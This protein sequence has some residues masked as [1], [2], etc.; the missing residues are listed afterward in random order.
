MTKL[1]SSSTGDSVI[2]HSH[3]T[4]ANT[5]VKRRDAAK[6]R[7]KALIQKMRLMKAPKRHPDP[8]TRSLGRGG[9]L[10]LMSRAC[11]AVKGSGGTRA[12]FHKN[13]GLVAEV[14][15]DRPPVRL[16]AA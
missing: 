11:Q 9:V 3:P 14:W 8:A 10:P 7:P 16:F 12:I 2:P 1:S 4:L 5:V 13:S 15:T 6:T